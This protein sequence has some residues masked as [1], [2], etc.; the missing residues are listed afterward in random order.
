MQK[1]NN[2]IESLISS[3]IN[4]IYQMIDANTVVGKP[5]IT[6]SGTVLPISKITTGFLTGGGEYGDV[7]FFKDEG[8][9]PFSG[10]MGAVVT[11]SPAAF[12]FDDKKC[13]R[14]VS[15]KQNLP[16]KIM[17]IFEEIVHSVKKDD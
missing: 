17:D 9:Y 11:V 10:G 13:F 16:E 15:T 6:E 8:N 12:I 3:A 1:E 2:N 14:L 7:K 5:I 4:S